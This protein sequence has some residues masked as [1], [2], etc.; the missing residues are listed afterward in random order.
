MN[1]GSSVAFKAED[2]E[3]ARGKDAVEK[4][5]AEAVAEEDSS[6]LA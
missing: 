6:N 1:H 3:K 5:A 4:A 2:R